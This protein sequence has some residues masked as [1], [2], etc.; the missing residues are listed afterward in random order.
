MK[1]IIDKTKPIRKRLFV[2]GAGCSYEWFELLTKDLFS[3]SYLKYKKHVSEDLKNFL[4]YLYP[5]NLSGRFVSNNVDIEDLLSTIDAAINVPAINAGGMFQKDRLEKIKNNLLELV[6]KGLWVPS[7]QSDSLYRKFVENIKPT[8]TLITFNYDTLLDRELVKR[9]DISLE[10]L[11]FHPSANIP[12]LLK[13]HGSVNWLFKEK[14][15]C[16]LPFGEVSSNSRN[17]A[18]IPPTLYKNP[19]PFQKLWKE[20][21]KYIKDADEILFIGYSLPQLDIPARYVFRR[22]IRLNQFARDVSVTV[23][24]PDASV[25]NKYC[26]LLCPEINFKKATFREYLEKYMGLEQTVPIR[27]HVKR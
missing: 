18:I 14:D 25:L 27:V 23:V 16:A 6:V 10:R 12:R 9:F 19:D 24:N 3:C 1:L 13:L 5:S 22:A 2:L 20:A 7:Y 4:K 8:D 11:Y 17:Y 15:I 21:R 26:N